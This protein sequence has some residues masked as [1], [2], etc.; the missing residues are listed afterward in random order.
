MHAHAVSAT[1][2]ALNNASEWQD[3]AI[4]AVQTAVV[5]V[6]LDLLRITRNAPWLE[7]QG[8]Q[9]RAIDARVVHASTDAA[10]G[11][12]SAARLRQCTTA[13]TVDFVS[14]QAVL[15]D[16][17]ARSWWAQTHKLVRMQARLTED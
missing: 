17:A 7:E 10:F 14:L 4:T 11:L 5:L 13:T 9:P 3:V 6:L 2:Y 15:F 12:T 16:G 8:A 1:R